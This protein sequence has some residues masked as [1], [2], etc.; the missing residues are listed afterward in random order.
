MTQNDLPAIRQLVQNGAL[1]IGKHALQ[2]MLQRGVSY[3][4]VKNILTS[5]TNQLIEYQSPSN[6]QGKEHPDERVLI[7]DPNNHTDAIVIAS[8]QLQ[9]Q[10]SIYVITVQKV[11]NAVWTRH[12]GQAPCLIRK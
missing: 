4:D 7:Y 9:P 3:D 5:N 1:I 6:T 2:R 10:P 11:D 8:P 12:N